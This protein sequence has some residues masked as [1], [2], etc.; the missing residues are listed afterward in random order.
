MAA[1]AITGVV[2]LVL[3][4]ARSLNQELTVEQIRDILAKNARL[5]PPDLAWNDRYSMRRVNAS[6]S[7]QQVGN[8]D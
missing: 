3:A 5:N 2:A 8:L 4:E 6:A 1:P 7:V